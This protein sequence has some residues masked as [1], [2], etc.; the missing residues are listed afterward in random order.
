MLRSRFHFIFISTWHILQKYS[1]NYKRTTLSQLSMLSV[2]K[3]TICRSSVMCP[4]HEHQRKGMR[5][6]CEHMCEVKRMVQYSHTFTHITRI[7]WV[8]LWFS[9]F[10]PFNIV[11]VVGAVRF[12][13]ACRKEVIFK[14]S[15]SIQF[16]YF[17][18]LPCQSSIELLVISNSFLFRLSRP[19]TRYFF[20]IFFSLAP[21]T[22][23]AGI[24]LR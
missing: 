23:C 15:S 4:A 16:I 2:R 3:R 11:R 18:C 12:S 8:V 6:R 22:S 1:C 17:L 14:R 7:H 24:V 21:Y 13:V 20:L 9:V 10:I 5:K 19:S